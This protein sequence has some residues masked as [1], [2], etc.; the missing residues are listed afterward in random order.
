MTLVYL[1][2]YNTK[3]MLALA[4]AIDRLHSG[5]FKEDGWN[6]GL[7]RKANKHLLFD[8][9]NKIDTGVVI[10]DQDREC[11]AAAE[12]NLRHLFLKSISSTLSDFERNMYNVVINEHITYGML[13]IAAFIPEYIRREQNKRSMIASTRVD[14][15]NSVYIN[16]PAAVRGMAVI[17]KRVYMKS[18]DRYMYTAAI[19]GNLIRFSTNDPYEEK[20]HIKITSCKIKGHMIDTE[21]GLPSTVIHYVRVKK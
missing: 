11:A 3:D 4:Y 5:Y 8:F 20:Q 19:G 1:K 15:A 9:V 7:V 6:N 2:Q 14:Y 12:S 17:V 18:Y 16:N 10:L 21:F 13:G